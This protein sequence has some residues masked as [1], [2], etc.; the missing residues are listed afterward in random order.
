MSRAV[1][2][3][4]ALIFLAGTAWAGAGGVRRYLVD[5]RV[6]LTVVP[7]GARSPGELA[8][9]DT[10]SGRN[11]DTAFA[12]VGDRLLLSGDGGRGEAHLLPNLAIVVRNAPWDGSPDHLSL[13]V[14]LD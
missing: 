11:G 7:C 13:G 3:A 9:Y 2:L 8:W 12:C 14:A 4:L 6:L 10:V 5:A 1:T